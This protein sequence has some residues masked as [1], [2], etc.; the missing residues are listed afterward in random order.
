MLTEK[1]LI[2]YSIEVR[3]EFLKLMYFNVIKGKHC[4][5]SPSGF[6]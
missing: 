5:M 4:F 1:D 6:E 3:L 2:E